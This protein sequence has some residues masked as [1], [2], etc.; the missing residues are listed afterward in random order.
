M[1]QA[2]AHYPGGQSLYANWAEGWGYSCHPYG[3]GADL[4]AMLR[5]P[6]TIAMAMTGFDN[7]SYNGCP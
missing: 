7:F 6:H 5:N 4:G 1:A 2:G 3:G